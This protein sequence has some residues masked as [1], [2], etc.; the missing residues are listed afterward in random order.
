MFGRRW[1]DADGRLT[2]YVYVYVYIFI[3]LS[4][5]IFIKIFYMHIIY[6]SMYRHWTLYIGRTKIHT[7]CMN[8]MHIHAYFIRI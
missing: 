4:V 3:G 2:V 8:F 5:Y 6:A 7:Y 1:G